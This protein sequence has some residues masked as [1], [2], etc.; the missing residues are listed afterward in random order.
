MT[1]FCVFLCICLK[2]SVQL[3]PKT[4]LIRICVHLLR[5]ISWLTHCVFISNIISNKCTRLAYIF[6]WILQC[7]LRHL[8]QM[9]W[10]KKKKFVTELRLQWSERYI[11]SNFLEIFNG[12]FFCLGIL[13]IKK[14]NKQ[15]N[16][17]YFNKWTK[18]GPN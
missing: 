16:N 3:N 9:G 6:S 17:N 15:T 12:N 2:L 5:K 11:F 18:P 13:R 14:T 10:F 7:N 8:P 4:K 1:N